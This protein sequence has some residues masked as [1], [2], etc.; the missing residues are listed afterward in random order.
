MAKTPVQNGSISVDPMFF[1]PD[2]VVGMGYS[3]ASSTA[4]STDSSEETTGVEVEN[5]DEAQE[6]LDYEQALDH[7]DTPQIISVISQTIRRGP[8][9]NNVVDVVLEVEDVEGA[10]SYEFRVAKA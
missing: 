8:G 10:S 1:I 9:G 4:G 5:A 3:P 7:I 2:G 6:G